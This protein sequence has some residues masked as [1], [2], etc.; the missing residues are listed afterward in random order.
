MPAEQS[1]SVQRFKCPGCSADMEFDPKSGALKCPYCG[2]TQ[3]IS[4]QVNETVQ[5]IPCDQYKDPSRLKK[6]SQTALQITCASCGSTIQCEP[7]EMTGSCPFCAA[8]F[9][10]QPKAADPLVAPNAILPFHLPKDKATDGVRQWLQDLWFAP[11]DLKKIARPEGIRGMY[12]PFWTFDARAEATY[13]GRRGEYYYVTETYYTTDSNGRQVRMERQVRHTRW[14]PASGRVSNAFDD[15]LVPA[16]RSVDAARLSKLEPWD[17]PRAQPYDPAYLPGFQAQRYQVELPEG[18][19]AAQVLMSHAVEHGV[20]EDIGGDEQIIDSLD[21]DWRDITFKHL[22]LP[23]WIG[24]Y[25]FHGK[26][27]QVIVNARTGE[28]QGER[29]WSA[30]KLAL[31]IVAVLIALVIVAK[32]W[33]N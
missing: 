19:Q 25:R 13:Q 5:E 17:L 21:I 16:T 29:P 8:N 20:R 31:L 9:V 12:T 30:A 18:L 15:V 28:V 10:S 24:A 22:L 14:Y 7:A 1:P 2:T 6:I 26:V 23:V 27:Y 32:L 3:A 33:P 11:S 4:R